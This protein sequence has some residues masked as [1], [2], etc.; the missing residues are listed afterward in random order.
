MGIK[1]IIL[2]A[3]GT[4]VEIARPTHPYSYLD[5]GRDIMKVNK[6]FEELTDDPIL[7]QEL[8]DELDSIRVFPDYPE[9]IKR[10][11]TIPVA[12]GSNLATPYATR[13]REILLPQPDYFHL[14]CEI[15]MMK[16]E[17]HF[18][19]TILEHF[20]V[21]PYEAL[22]IGDSVRNDFVTPA[23]LGIRSVLVNRGIGISLIDIANQHL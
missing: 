23:K 14:S 5:V 12:I 2:D 15:G 13:L 8:R 7:R 3:F 17:H 21:Q 4:C 19:L 1:L 16:P 9:F 6:S 22:M 10:T 20:G 11:G 18:Y